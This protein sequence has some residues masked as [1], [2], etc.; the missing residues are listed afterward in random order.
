MY[1]TIKARHEYASKAPT[2]LYRFD[3]DSE[4]LES[5]YRL[6]RW[7]RG[8]KG[9]SHTDDLTYL[10][11]NCLSKRME[12]KSREYLTIQRMIG[13]WVAFAETGN[14]NM[15]KI[16]GMKHVKWHRSHPTAD[17]KIKCL[18]ISDTLEYIDLPEIPKL[19][20]WNELYNLHRE[21]PKINELVDLSIY[22]K[23]SL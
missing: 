13:L 19:K 11:S 16:P 10:F 17:D 6:I 3:F 15:G 14:P 5:P 23:S 22:T 7:G 9:A 8:I 12:L 21:L 18:N 1:K 2:Y 4:K 20:V